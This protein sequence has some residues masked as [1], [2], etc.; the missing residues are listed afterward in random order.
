MTEQEIHRDEIKAPE[1]SPGQILSA[2]RLAQG[3]EINELADQIK[4]PVN[5]LEA[6]EKDRIPK[7]LPETFIRGYIRSYARKVG[8]E[9]S[10]VL[11]QI[12]TTAAFEK[13]DTDH[14]EMQSFSRRN[15]RKALE[16]RL[17]I[18]TWIIVL[19]L[20]LAA[21]IWWWQDSK[22]QDFAPV[23]GAANL[24]AETQRS[25]ASPV[26]V[27]INDGADVETDN[28]ED[29]APSN[30][31]ENTG[32]AISSEQ[33][34][35]VAAEPEVLEQG[36]GDDTSASNLADKVVENEAEPTPETT[37]G[38]QP[39]QLTEAQKALVADNGEVDEEGFMKVEMHFENDCWVEVYDA[40]EERIAIGNKPAGYLMTLNAQGPFNVLL[41]NPVGVSIWVNGKE[42]NTSELPRNRVARFE[43][44]VVE[45]SLEVVH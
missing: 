8:V 38:Q 19:V 6:I 24:N 7:N 36:N 33:L 13:P 14:Q 41:G 21:A 22:T 2:A 39:V 32:S 12:E 20:I 40:N 15:K 23:A 5:V 10:Q 27:A 11:T 35:L 43:L 4:V 28:T 9:E 1:Q 16:R 42:F 26:E 34:A 29:E 30:S 37:T 31:A 18:A 17:T 44:D 25:D 3:I 45:D